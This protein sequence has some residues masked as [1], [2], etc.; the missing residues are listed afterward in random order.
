MPPVKRLLQF[1]RL[2]SNTLSTQAAFSRLQRLQSVTLY[3]CPFYVAAPNRE[4]R[5]SRPADVVRR[6]PQGDGA[7]PGPDATFDGGE[8]LPGITAVPLPGHTPG[9]TG[10]RLDGGSRSLLVWGD[11]VHLPQVQAPEPEAGVVF[12]V[13][14]DQA[15]RTRRRMLDEA[16]TDRLLVAGMHTEFP[17]LANVIREGAGYRI[18]PEL[19]ATLQP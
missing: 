7:L 10:F 8:V 11:I 6:R 3:L 17:G 1:G 5:R 4:P 15:V 14:G 9:H 16:A 13:D 18:V 12:D 19:W 2:L